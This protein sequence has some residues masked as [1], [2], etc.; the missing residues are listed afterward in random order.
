M[1]ILNGKNKFSGASLKYVFKNPRD[2]RSKTFRDEW[3][4]YYQANS[5][6]FQNA[7]NAVLAALNPVITPLL[8][9]PQYV[10]LKTEYRD[11]MASVTDRDALEKLFLEY[12]DKQL[13]L[14]RS[15]TPSFDD[16]VS[17]AISAYM[18]YLGNVG[19]L[20]DAITRKPVFSV[21]YNF[22]RPQGQP[23]VSHFRLMSTLNPF[24]PNGT[25]RS[26]QPGHSITHPQ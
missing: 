9:S 15:V 6:Q 12:L 14:A 25:L 1:N 19:G 20:L 8:T 4:T 23:D 24:G 18:R 3:N 11:K 2:V 13:A 10:A 21:E 16:Q 17:S 5:Q 26:M 22:E 7:G